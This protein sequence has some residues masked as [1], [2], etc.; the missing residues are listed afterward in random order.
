MRDLRGEARTLTLLRESITPAF[1]ALLPK[2]A[3]AS[4]VEEQR[5]PEG[6]PYPWQSR[7]KREARD[8]PGGILYVP[9]DSFFSKAASVAQYDALADRVARAKALILDL[10]ENG[11][12]N[13]EHAD[14]IVSRLT[15]KPAR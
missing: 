2:P 11:G 4:L 10:R 7:P 15:D 9:V 8:L 13:S 5:G 14:A 1:A 6:G 12:G 3:L